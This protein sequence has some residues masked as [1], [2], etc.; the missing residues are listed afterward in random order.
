MPRFNLSV[1]LAQCEHQVGGC[2]EPQALDLKIRKSFPSQTP[3]LGSLLSQPPTLLFSGSD[4]RAT[5]SPSSSRRMR[6][7]ERNGIW[8]HLSLGLFYLEELLC[9]S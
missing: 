7:P 4:D 2:E 8:V 9:Q 5:G 3:P 6:M 1:H